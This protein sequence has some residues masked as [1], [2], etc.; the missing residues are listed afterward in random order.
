[1]M[2]ASL[3][4][5]ARKRA[6][7]APDPLSIFG[8]TLGLWLTH[9]TGVSGSPVSTWGDQSGKGNDATEATNQPTYTS[10]TGVIF[11][12]SNDRLEVAD[13][14]TLDATTTLIV[15]ICVNPD[16]TTSNRVPICKSQTGS[17]TWSMQSNTTGMR[18]HAGTP[19]SNFGEISSALSAGVTSRIIVRYDGG[20][21]GNSGRLRMYLNGSLQSPSYTGTIPATLTADS[22]SVW[23]GMYGNAAQ[24]WDGVIKG[25]VIAI[26]HSTADQ[27]ITDLDTYLSTL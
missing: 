14:A 16:V 10:G 9:V 5:C 2:S 23:L 24:F 21:S 15:G 7:A 18:W 19:G 26:G 22:N 4:G 1:M 25:A 13:D 3:M 6:A 12:G 20:G 11:D 27:D 8:S 17:G